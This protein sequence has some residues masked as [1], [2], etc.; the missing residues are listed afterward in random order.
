MVC[1]KGRR[2]LLPF[3]CSPLQGEV[4]SINFSLFLIYRQS[5][6]TDKWTGFSDLKGVMLLVHMK[7]FCHN[8][9]CA[10]SYL[11]VSRS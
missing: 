8:Y 9:L 6:D 11:M 5:M 4:G 1:K 3:S 7:L 10:S 2:N